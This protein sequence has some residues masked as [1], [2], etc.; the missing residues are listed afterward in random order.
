LWSAATGGRFE[1]AAQRVESADS[2]KAPL[3]NSG[4]KPP[5]SKGF[6]ETNHH[7]IWRHFR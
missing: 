7:E 2:G 4:V 6:Y 1:L 5:H 3:L